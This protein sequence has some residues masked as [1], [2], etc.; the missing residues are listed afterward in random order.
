MASIVGVK[1]AVD[2]DIENFKFSDGWISDILR[3]HEIKRVNLHG[4]K[5]D[6][7]QEEY[8]KVMIPCR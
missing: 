2:L 8:E 1:W 3:H 6:T 4:K 7:T 5:N